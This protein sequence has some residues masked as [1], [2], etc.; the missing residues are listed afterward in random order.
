MQTVVCNDLL[1]KEGLTW[2]SLCYVMQD[3]MAY[4]NNKE[5]EKDFSG[6]RDTIFNSSIL[7][8]V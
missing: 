6:N 1:F 2:T 4:T 3:V 5:R 8:D 7:K